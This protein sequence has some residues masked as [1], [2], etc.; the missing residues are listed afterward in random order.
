[1]SETRQISL[2]D[3]TLESLATIR[4]QLRDAGMM[5]VLEHKRDGVRFTVFA[6]QPA[7]ERVHEA[8][9]KT[10]DEWKWNDVEGRE[11][12]P[13]SVANDDEPF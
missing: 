9:K 7:I 11:R 5:E 3:S 1:M 8:I 13:S 2:S 6:N 12:L 10:V 4:T